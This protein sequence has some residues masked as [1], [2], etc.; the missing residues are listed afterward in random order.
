M[1]DMDLQANRTRERRPWAKWFV[2]A[3]RFASIQAFTQGLGFVI[4]IFI[5][6]KLTKPEYAVYTLANTMLASILLLAD[7]GI[8][9]AMTSIGG[10]VWQDTKALGQLVASAMRLRRYLAITTVCLV[11]PVMVWLLA[12]N[13]ATP[14]QVVVVT[15]L[16]LT[17]CAFEFLTR[18]YAVVLRLRSERSRLQINAAIGVFVRGVL[19][20]ALWMRLNAIAALLGAV[21]GCWLQFVLMRKWTRDVRET[22]AHPDPGMV[23]EIGGII[24][25]QAPN[26]LFYCIQGQITVW[27][28][29]V[30]GH[31]SGVA[32]VGALGR[33][34]AILAVLNTTLNEVIFPAFAR[35]QNPGVVR[36]R[37]MELLALYAVGCAVFVMLFA[38]FPRPFL[39]LL[40][41]KYMSLEREG[42]LMAINV[43][44]AAFAGLIWGLNATR[45]WILYPWP[46]V[47]IVFGAQ[48]IMVRVMNLSTVRGAL[49]F[50]IVSALIGTLWGLVV[51]CDGMLKENRKHKAVAVAA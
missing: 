40:G 3:S 37:Y 15:V 20:A 30:F 7:S 17:G 14:V 19:L 6:R 38:Q 46:Q 41:P 49:I 36:T 9:S 2:I 5:I 23:A 43:T 27:I 42:M 28:I 31:S 1:G 45:A 21:A 44:V 11:T 51:S 32:D 13:G 33:L 39:W 29:S 4:G 22:G 34:V 10:R 8:G 47:V 48:W 26:V 25:K 35:I 50:S 24:K 12:R 18:I 16:V